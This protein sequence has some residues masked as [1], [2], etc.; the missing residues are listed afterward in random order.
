MQLNILFIQGRAVYFHHKHIAD[1]ISN[2]CPQSNRLLT[3]LHDVEVPHFQ[4]TFRALCIINKLVAGPL[5]RLIECHEDHIFSLNQ[6]TRDALKLY[7]VDLQPLL[8]GKEVVPGGLV[9]VD[10][11][12]TEIFRE[13][14]DPEMDELIG[15]CL[16][17][18]CGS[19]WSGS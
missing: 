8:E 5:F 16:R 7:T 10:E 17:L 14:Q 6:K 12:Y 15:D 1:L 19:S 9:K 4:D 18:L 11:I 3:A 2:S 13:P